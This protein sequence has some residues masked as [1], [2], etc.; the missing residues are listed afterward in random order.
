MRRFCV[1]STVLL[2]GCSLAFAS[3][4]LVS[5]HPDAARISLPAGA[6]FQEPL[7]ATAPTTKAEDSALTQALD[8]YA[9]RT[10]PDD[11]SA[12]EGFVR[13]HPGSAWNIALET[14]LGLL[15]YHFGYFTRAIAEWDAAWS[16]G[17]DLKDPRSKAMVDRALGELIRMNLSAGH[18][19]RVEALLKEIGARPVTGSA[20]ESVN[21]AKDALWMLQNHP[22]SSTL[23]GPEAL[24]NLL[25]SLGSTREQ[26]GFLDNFHAGSKGVSLSELAQL[27]DQAKLDYDVVFRQSEQAIPVP[28][29]VHWKFWPLLR[30][31][32]RSQRQVS[33]TGPRV[34]ARSVGDARCA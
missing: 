13:Q 32:R 17:K 28:S 18:V 4:D 31:C 27:A 1:S 26:V 20:T 6:R 7:I 21:D 34:S 23:C 5:N 8:A 9:R 22:E 30:Y 3:S 25:M 19:D 11:L 12:L 15:D 14:N 24:K 16:Q 29:I 33:R 10:A 2:L